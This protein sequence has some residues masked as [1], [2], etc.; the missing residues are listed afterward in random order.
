MDKLN[1]AADFIRLYATVFD[2]IIGDGGG[3]N[4]LAFSIEFWNEDGVL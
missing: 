4:C 2:L 1:R 3:G